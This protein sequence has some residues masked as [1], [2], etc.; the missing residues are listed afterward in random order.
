MP[1][2]PRIQRI[3][4]GPLTTPTDLRFKP[5]RGH[6]SPPGTGPVGESCRSCRHRSPTDSNYR[7]W[8]CGLIPHH[9]PDRGQAIALTEEACGR[10][11]ARR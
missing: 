7:V 1:V 4:D 3:L 2:D 5:L 10:W 6:V 9:R 11:E 8:F